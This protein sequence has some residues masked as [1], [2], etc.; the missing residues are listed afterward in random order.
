MEG[1]DGEMN[2]QTGTF[3]VKTTDVCAKAIEQLSLIPCSLLDLP[4]M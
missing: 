1:R 4:T 3:Q 2:G